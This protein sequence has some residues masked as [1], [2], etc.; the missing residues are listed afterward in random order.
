MNRSPASRFGLVCLVVLLGQAGCDRSGGGKG[1]LDAVLQPADKDQPRP[2]QD[3]WTGRDDLIRSPPAAEPKAVNFPDVERFELKNGLKVRVVSD[4]AWPVVNFHMVVLGGSD[5]EPLSQRSLSDFT[6]AMLT[7]GTDIFDVWF[8]S[9]SS[10]FAAA[11]QRKLV[12]DIPIDMY[13]EG[14]DQHRG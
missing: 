8:E 2:E 10:W 13:L 14:S 5:E 9:G 3:P 1:T 7:K 6:A 4:H 11:V 12:D